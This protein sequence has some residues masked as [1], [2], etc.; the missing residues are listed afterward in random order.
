MVPLPAWVNVPVI[1]PGLDVAVYEVIVAPPFDPGAVK[2]TDAVPL[3]PVTE[4]VPMVGAPG[5]V[6]A[7]AN[8]P[9]TLTLSIPIP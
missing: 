4:A 1:L 3:I 7:E 8:A 5:T 2:G 6:A 9:V